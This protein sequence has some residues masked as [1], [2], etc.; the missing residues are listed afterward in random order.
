[1]WT[2][3]KPGVFNGL[4]NL[5]RLDLYS[6]ILKE[7]EPG[8][9]NGLGNLMD[10]DLFSN[11]LKEIQPGAFNGLGNLLILYVSNNR[12][13]GIQP[14]VFNELGNLSSL[15]LNNN[16]LKEIQPGALNGL[17]NL[18]LLGLN[19]NMLTVIQPGVFSGMGKLE[20]LFLNNNMLTRLLPTVF[21]M[22]TS[23]V[24]LDLSHNPLAHMHP[25]TFQNLTNL[26]YLRLR[27]ISLTFLPDNIFQA[28][29]QL[30]YLDLSANDLNE[31]QSHPFEICT[32][33]DTIDLTHNSLKWIGKDSFIG[34]NVSARVLVDKP[35]SCCFVTKANCIPKSSKSPFLSCG[36]LLPYDVLRVWIWIISISAILNNVLS[37]LVN[38][39]QR[40]Q[41]NKVQF[42]LI[43]NLAISDFLMG[44][45]LISLLSV[46]L[47]YTDYFP[48]HSEA[49]RNSN[50]CKIGGSLSVLS[51][52][53]S[54]FF[55][56]MISS[57]RAFAIN[58]PFRGHRGGT[59]S[60]CIIVAFLW[61]IAFGISITSYVLSE[62]D[63]DV[64]AVPEICVGLPFSRQPTYNTS[65]TSV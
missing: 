46:N 1:M 23:L 2:E 22:L 24:A 47:Y 3:I 18:T 9:F 25:D 17:G 65:K 62:M 28:L 6:N 55:I 19:N 42:L 43:T 48:S 29:W 32:I 57:D 61:L 15:P 16:M 31:L 63:S 30:R 37:I 40:K 33:L 8:V 35:A 64:Y 60:T 39:K 36:R 10:L 4:G 52:E 21:G 49:W 13:E 59:K 51:S 45:Y 53:V 58:F 20:W 41:V 27:N 34:L 38:C 5:S 44:L 12:L 11:M 26:D 54:V 7:I 50:L 14:G 56:T